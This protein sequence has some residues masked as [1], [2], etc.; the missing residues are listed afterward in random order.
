[1]KILKYKKQII[2]IILILMAITSILIQ[3]NNKIVVAKT[4]N[5]KENENSIIVY[6]VGAV[7]KEGLYNCS[8]KARLDD[9]INAAGGLTKDADLQNINF[10]KKIIDGEKIIIPKIKNANVQEETSDKVNIG[11]ATKEELKTLDGIGDS[12]A[13]KILQYRD[14]N[15]FNT[16]EDLLEIPGIGESKYNKI[17]EKV[18]I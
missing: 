16:V 1:M 14:E 8:N 6:V 4:N 18:Y 11:T 2:L 13:D 5:N 17:K 7:N 12:T 10:A 9:I 3:K 15:G